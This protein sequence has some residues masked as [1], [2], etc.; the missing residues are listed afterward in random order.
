[1]RENTLPSGQGRAGFLAVSAE[2]GAA[3]G[4]AGV[5]AW[6]L[7]AASDTKD[8]AASDSQKDGKR[9]DILMFSWRQAMVRRCTFPAGCGPEVCQGS[10]WVQL[11]CLYRRFYPPFGAPAQRATVIW[12]FS[13]RIQTEGQ[14]MQ[15]NPGRPTL[16]P[17]R[18]RLNH[19]SDE[20]D[21]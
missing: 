6:A 20:L 13:T 7:N 16:G 5:W 1:M 19:L 18:L 4:L 15:R 21:R 17:D 11:T 9:L 8:D 10:F 12:S 2:F 3:S 14:K